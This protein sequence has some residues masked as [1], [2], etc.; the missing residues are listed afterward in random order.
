MTESVREPAVAGMFYDRDREG[1]DETI[2]NLLRG[3]PEGPKYNSVISPHAGYPYSGRTAA[4]AL[5]SL[6][7][8][9]RFIIMGPNHTGLGSPFSMMSSGSWKTPLGQAK[10]DAPLSKALEKCG[11][12]EDDELAHSKEH[13]I[14]VQLPFLQK[15]FGSI[16]FVTISIMGF[17]YNSAL[18]SSCE[19]LGSCLAK[20]IQANPD[21]RVIAS[22]DFSHYISASSAQEKD[23][24]AIDM[25]RDLDAEGFFRV[26]H[27]TRASVCG[28]APIAILM[29]VARKL[30]WKRAEVLDY[31]NS[32][33]ATGDHS[34]VVS[35]AAIGFRK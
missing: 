17:G 31:T 8:S 33:E 15:L 4:R 2:S 30:G 28:Y 27:E 23:K 25:I 11:L 1:L 10:I 35:Y 18:L 21:V 6:I 34:Q 22:S 7:P 12:L 19:E 29:I 32:G 20:L 9:K 5:S 13:S 14:E 3:I 24:K 26:L 16:S